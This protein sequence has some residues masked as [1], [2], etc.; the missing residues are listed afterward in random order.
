M[1]ETAVAQEDRERWLKPTPFLDRDSAEVREFVD[2]HAGTGSDR[3]RAVRLYLAVRDEIL[4]DPYSIRIEPGYFRASACLAAGRGFC[5]SK[6]IVLAAVARAAGI[7]ARLGFADVK[8][9][10]ATP[11]LLELMGTDIFHYHGYTSLLIDGSWVKATPAFNLGLCTRFGIRPLEFDGREDSI[12]HPFDEAGRQHMEYVAERGEFDDLPY[13]VLEQLFRTVYPR[14]GA[15]V[16]GD[17]GAE[18]EAER[19]RAKAS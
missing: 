17:F 1:T 13:E 3:E 18:A 2:R 10:L 8:N 16:G 15:P 19:K 9:H 14:I 11:R 5:I 12:F 6:A 7:P 4:Y